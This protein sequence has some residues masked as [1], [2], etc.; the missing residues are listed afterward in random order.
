MHS[1]NAATPARFNVRIH[2]RL[3][4]CAI[5]CAYGRT[6]TE[7]VMTKNVSETASQNDHV[8]KPWRLCP[9]RR[10]VFVAMTPKLG[11]SC[12]A[13]ILAICASITLLSDGQTEKPRNVS[14]VSKSPGVFQIGLKPTDAFN[15]DASKD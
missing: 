6:A 2:L 13:V 5:S 14:Y 4:V 11:S 3:N 12:A 8:I 9:A 10:R 1:A 15:M 7:P